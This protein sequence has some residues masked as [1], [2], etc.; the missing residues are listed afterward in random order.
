MGFPRR[1]A[2]IVGVYTTEQGRGLDRTSFS[3]EL[4]AIKGA[5]AEAGLTVDDVDGVVP[6]ST[7]SLYGAPSP[8]QFWATQL[9]GRPLTFAQPGSP[10]PSIAKAALA[11]SAGMCEVAIVF[12]GKAGWQLGP[13][14]TPVPTS[15][16]RVQEWHYDLF[17]GGYAQFYAL[18]AQ[19]YMHEFGATS[20]DLAEVA[21]VH[22]EHALRNP[23]SVMGSRGPLTVEDVVTSRLITSPLHLYDC[24]LDTDGG[25]A[26]VLASAGV[27]RNCATPPVW[28]IGGGEAVHTDFYATID[29]PWFPDEGQ[30]VRRAGEIAFAQAGVTRDDIDVAGLYDCFTITMIRD[31]EELG[32]CKVGEGAEYVK[33]GN[34]RLGGALPCNTDGGLLSNSHNGMPHGMH[35]IEVVRQLRGEC[36]D[37]QVPGATIGLSLAQGASVHGY[38]GTLIMATD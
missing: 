37:R 29:D 28:I 31:L 12:W 10:T 9:G 34:T 22:R 27:A 20:E 16:P 19:R 35:T 32:Y 5:V 14:G 4:E 26:L 15:A 21:V 33:E 25:Y 13:S 6:M 36:G 3:L 2:A 23:D 17:G 8:E 38:A 1:A 11:I 7:R 24:A 18:W 30:S